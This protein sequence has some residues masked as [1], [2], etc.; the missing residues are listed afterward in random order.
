LKKIYQNNSLKEKRKV[1]YEVEHKA[2]NKV[3]VQFEYPEGYSV[4]H[5]PPNT[6]FNHDL[7]GFEF[8][9]E[10]KPGSIKQT[11]SQYDNFLLLDPPH[12]EQWNKMIKNLNQVHRK[13]TILKK[14]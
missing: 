11:L 5:I 6:N 10:Q 1:P 12:F 13:S 2:L 7:F 14:P 9:S 3:I 8:I 4:E